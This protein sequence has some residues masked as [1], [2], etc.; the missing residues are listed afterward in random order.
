MCLCLCWCLYLSITDI[1]F[2]EVTIHEFRIR[3]RNTR[4]RIRKRI[5]WNWM[6][7]AT[8]KRRNNDI[9]TK[10]I[11]ALIYLPHIHLSCCAICIVWLNINYF[12]QEHVTSNWWRW[13]QRPNALWYIYI[14]N[15]SIVLIRIGIFFLCV[16]YMTEILIHTKFFSTENYLVWLFAKLSI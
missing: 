13:Q 3:W 12:T 16:K 1:L 4:H 5:I 14:I 15:I 2:Y 8:I 9:E 6:T 10:W 11:D 7:L